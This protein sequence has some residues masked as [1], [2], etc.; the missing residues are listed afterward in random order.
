MLGPKEAV[1]IYPF[2]IVVHSE[3]ADGDEMIVVEWTDEIEV[4]KRGMVVRL[5]SWIDNVREAFQ[6][7]CWVMYHHLAFQGY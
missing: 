1:I 3:I 7:L 6:V 5:R 4:R 2:V